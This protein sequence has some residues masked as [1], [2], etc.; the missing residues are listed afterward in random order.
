V[1]QG[2]LHV[3]RA[4]ATYSAALQLS[5]RRGQTRGGSDTLNLL[6]QGQGQ[7]V[8]ARSGPTVRTRGAPQAAQHAP[9]RL[10]LVGQDEALRALG[11]A[12]RGRRGGAQ[13]LLARVR[14]QARAQVRRGRQRVALQ[15]A[16][17]RLQLPGA[18]RVRGGWQAR[19]GLG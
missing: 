4:C 9:P 15:A 12:P 7:G 18:R 17:Q 16:L 5:Q 6:Q 8:D 13:R 1:A 2:L 10:K 14:G 3:R 19:I 11:L